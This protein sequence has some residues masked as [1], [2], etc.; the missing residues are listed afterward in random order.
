MLVMVE[1]KKGDKMRKFTFF[2]EVNIEAENEDDARIEL[3]NLM[4]KHDILW[5]LEE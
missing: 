1:R 4:D 3:I 5:E 2:A